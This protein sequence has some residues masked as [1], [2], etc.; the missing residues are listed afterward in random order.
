VPKA[1]KEFIPQNVAGIINIGANSNI[2]NDGHKWTL[3][4]VGGR[5]RQNYEPLNY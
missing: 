1:H 2:V 4:P 3:A 5:L